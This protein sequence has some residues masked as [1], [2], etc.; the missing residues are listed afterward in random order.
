[1]S[2]GHGWWRGEILQRQGIVGTITIPLIRTDTEH[3]TT[4]DR[5]R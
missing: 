5:D 1:M 3:Y 4:A 2:G